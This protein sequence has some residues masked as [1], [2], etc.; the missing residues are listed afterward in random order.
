MAVEGTSF[1]RGQRVY[2]PERGFAWTVL[3]MVTPFFVIVRDSRNRTV[4]RSVRELKAADESER[5]NH[6]D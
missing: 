3:Q 2:E 6:G 4:R 1:K 5:T